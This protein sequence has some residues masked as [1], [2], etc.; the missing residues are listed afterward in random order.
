MKEIALANSE[1]MALVDDAD[2]QTVAGFR[3]SLQRQTDTR[4]EYAARY[5]GENT[6]LMHRALMPEVEFIDHRSGDGLDNQRSN[7]RACTQQQNQWNRR[8]FKGLSS[9]KGV[10]RDVKK[11]GRV[12][13]RAR[14]VVNGKKLSLGYFRSELGAALAYD[15][16][17]RF[18]FGEFA[19][20]NF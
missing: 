5:E 6:I 17:A 3:W 9:F 1:K 4:C 10:E 18:F 19:R 14:I 2:A 16:A 13:W 11:S 7:L 20:P 12:K 8:K 15:A